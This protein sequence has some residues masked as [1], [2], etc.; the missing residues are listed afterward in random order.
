[1]EKPLV[2]II[3]PVYKVENYLNRCV[4]SILMQSYKNIEVILVDDGSP[5][6]CPQICDEYANLD[7]RVEVIHKKN[8]GLSDARNIGIEKAKGEFFSFI[9]SDDYVYP[10]MIENLVNIH[11]NTGANMVI[12][13]FKTVDEAGNRVEPM[14]SSPILNGLFSAGEIMPQIYEGMGWYY[15]VAWNKLYHRSLFEQI[16]FPFG[17][18]HEDEYVVTQLMWAAKKIACLSKE[19][20]VY[21]Y[22]RNG[23]IMDLQKGRSQ[24]DWLEA[25]YLRFLFCKEQGMEELATLTRTVYFRELNNFFMKPEMRAYATKKQRK[26]AK[27]QYAK[28]DGKSVTEWINWIIFLINPQ[29]DNALVKLIRKMRS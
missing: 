9:D 4:D 25:M 16:R 11:R 27:R 10:D 18:I 7:E 29:I 19:E 22:Q 8:G 24:C 6:K 17:K 28:M 13:N 14:E 2:S 12:T 3:V 1:M 20:Y 26:A 21:L 5:D 15:I 23:S